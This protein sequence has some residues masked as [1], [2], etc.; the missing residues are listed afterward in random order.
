MSNDKIYSR[1]R[2]KLPNVRFIGGI[3]RR[4]SKNDFKR[5][6]TFKVSIIL[7]IALLTFGME[8][9]AISPIID[10][11]C[12][13]AA[14]SKATIITNDKSTEVM[15]NYSYDD[16]VKIYRDDA[17][18]ITMLQSNIIT[19]NEITSDIATKIQKAILDENEN[20][21]KIKFGSLSGIRVLSGIGPDIEIKFVS[22][23]N[24]ETK[25]RSEF[26]SIGINQTIHRIY[27]DIECTASILT[28]Y[29]VVDEKITN[30]VVL[31]ENV[32][33]RSYTINLL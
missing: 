16:F 12:S 9:R 18:N 5:N 1:R 11:V 3:G 25:V 19:I 15:K 21:M 30:E 31:I 23:G 28:P 4:H 8:I 2:I 26:E 6:F 32:V 24:I 22:T 10:K 7:I 33:V 27:L 17:G 20:A 14:K 29:K 13:D